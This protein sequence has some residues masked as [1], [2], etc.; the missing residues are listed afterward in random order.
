MIEALTY[1]DMLDHIRENDFVEDMIGIL[2]TRPS[3]ATGKDIVGELE[4]YHHLTGHAINFYLPG[5]GAYWNTEEYP[6]MK[7]V[8]E[9]DRTEWSFS[10]KSFVEFINALEEVSRWKYSGESELLL[11]PYH[12][13]KLD[14]SSVAVFCLDA[15]LKDETI[16]S[17][18]RFITEL[19]RSARLNNEVKSIVAKG[20]TKCVTKAIAQEMIDSFF[21]N[22]SKALKRG[23]HYFCKD[24]SR[25]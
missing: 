22:V 21:R 11:I 10:S 20:A 3:L 16:S 13:G 15:M 1:K 8:T 9:I 17:V 7:V 19:S 6:D 23:R 2:I 18:S 5:Y 25:Y 12:D 24:F 4:Y 14:F